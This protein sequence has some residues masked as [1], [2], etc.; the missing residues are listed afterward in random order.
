MNIHENIM[1]KGEKYSKKYLQDNGFNLVNESTIF[2][3]YRKGINAFVFEQPKF[4]HED[5]YILFAIWKD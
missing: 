3:F 5:D 2:L 4:K 1:V